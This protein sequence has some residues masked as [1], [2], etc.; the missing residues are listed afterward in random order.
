MRI[1]QADN[2]FFINIFPM[3]VYFIANR[4]LR[5]HYLFEFGLF[6]PVST[7]ANND[8]QILTFANIFNGI[9]HFN[10]SLAFLCVSLR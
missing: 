5:P 6:W 3:A 2:F 8:K 1:K 9:S 4:H 10:T 7:L